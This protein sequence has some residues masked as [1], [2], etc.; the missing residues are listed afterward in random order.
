MPNM[1][2]GP[3]FL[4]RLVRPSASERSVVRMVMFPRKIPARRSAVPRP[5]KPTGQTRACAT[6]TFSP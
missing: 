5:C 3:L 1:S 4:F 6:N 2:Q